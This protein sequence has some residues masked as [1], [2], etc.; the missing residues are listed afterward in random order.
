MSLIFANFFTSDTKPLHTVLFVQL[1][2]SVKM[3]INIVIAN[4][5]VREMH[6][7]GISDLHFD[8]KWQVSS[9]PCWFEKYYLWIDW[10]LSASILLVIASNGLKTFPVINNEMFVDSK[11]RIVN[12]KDDFFPVWKTMFWSEFHW[13][14]RGREKP[15]PALFG[16]ET[17]SLL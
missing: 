14:C 17:K 2:S 9:Y 12:N 15:K 7:Q 3:F 11:T 10:L 4:E 5:M 6:L 8:F 1:S 13:S 16:S